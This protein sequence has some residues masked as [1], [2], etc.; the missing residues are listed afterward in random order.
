[1]GKGALGSGEGGLDVSSVLCERFEG[2]GLG[3]F[4]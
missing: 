1:M 2:V 4:F 3:F